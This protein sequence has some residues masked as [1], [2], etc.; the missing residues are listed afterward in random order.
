MTSIAVHLQTQVQ[1]TFSSCPQQTVKAEHPTSMYLDWFEARKHSSF[2]KNKQKRSSKFSH[3]SPTCV[4]STYC[5]GFEARARWVCPWRSIWFQ[6]PDTYMC[7]DRAKVSEASSEFYDRS[8]STK[9]LP[10]IQLAL[11]TSRRIISIH[12]L[13]DSICCGFCQASPGSSSPPT[14]FHVRCMVSLGGSL[15]H[16]CK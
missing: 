8:R 15:I 2:K 12:R 10:D 14:P 1:N 11:V 16:F 9:K 4:C 3:R 5:K 7:F 13:P 6:T